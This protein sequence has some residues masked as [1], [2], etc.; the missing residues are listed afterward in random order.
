MFVR[1]WMQTNFF[2]RAGSAFSGVSC[3]SSIEYAMADD[4]GTHCHGHSRQDAQLL[5]WWPPSAAQSISWEANAIFTFVT[6]SLYIWAPKVIQGHRRWCAFIN[7]AANICIQTIGTQSTH[8]LKATVKPLRVVFTFITLHWP[9]KG[10]QR[11][12][13]VAD[14]KLRGQVPFSVP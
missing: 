12:K 1:N 9:L 3:H 11:W 10:Q 2:K 14:P 4:A 5:L 8:G 13:F 7:L 6:F